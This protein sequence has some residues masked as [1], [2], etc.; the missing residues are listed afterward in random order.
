[1]YKINSQIFKAIELDNTPQKERYFVIDDTILAKLG[2][3]I[4]NVS[5]IIG[6]IRAECALP[7]Q[8]LHECPPFCI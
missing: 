5:Y 3:K 7:M 2:K 1:M 4:E 6:D 8:S